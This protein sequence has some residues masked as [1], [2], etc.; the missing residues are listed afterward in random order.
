M[1][2]SVT[3]TAA[4]LAATVAF[5]DA[6]LGALGLVR[7][8]ELVDEEED[9]PALEAVAWGPADGTSVLWVVG[10]DPPTTGL[11]LRFRARSRPEVETFHAAGESAGGRTHAAPRRWPIYRRGEFNAI[12]RDPQ[13][14]LVEAVAPE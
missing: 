14:N 4:D 11:H 3:I 6:A 1:L 8:D 7:L 12:L 13:G 2:D 5:Y 9:E 10:G